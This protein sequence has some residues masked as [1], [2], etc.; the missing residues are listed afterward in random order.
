MVSISYG[1]YF[2]ETAGKYIFVVTISENISLYGFFTQ[3]ILL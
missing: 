3:N 1:D 2:P